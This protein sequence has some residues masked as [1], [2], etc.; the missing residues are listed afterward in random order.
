MPT[1][2][3]FALISMIVYLTSFLPTLAWLLANYQ[4]K[5]RCPRPAAEG[6]RWSLAGCVGEQAVAAA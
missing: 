6:R 3:T 4:Q 1:A 5:P 2:D